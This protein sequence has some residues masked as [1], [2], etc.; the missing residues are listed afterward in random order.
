MKNIK[1]GLKTISFFLFLFLIGLLISCK[2]PK[3]NIYN[4]YSWISEIHND[5]PRLFFNNKSF[6]QI[7]NR[8]LNDEN[9]LFGEMKSRVDLLIGQKI[10]FSDPLVPDGTQNADHMYGTRAAE[11]AFVYL[12]SE[13][14][15]YLDLSKEILVSLVDYY[16]LRNEN[17]LNI[18]WYAFSRINAL[19]A[20]DWIYNDLTEKDSSFPLDATEDASD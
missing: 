12:V 7:K 10:E 5:H 8:A 20:Y 18:Q 16:T 13:D 2:N 19:A 3:E 15:K 17:D 6:K 14:E 1:I 4:N 9:E 11:A